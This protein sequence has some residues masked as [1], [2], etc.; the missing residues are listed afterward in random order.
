MLLA[1]GRLSMMSVWLKSLPTSVITMR[2]MT[3]VM[4]PGV[5]GTTTRMG[6]DGYFVCAQTSAVATAINAPATD[7]ANSARKLIDSPPAY[8]ELL[9]E[10]PRVARS[11]V[12]YSI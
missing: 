6:R 8:R 10:R 3:S 4:P 9:N 12:S 1:P 2:V 7:H 5:Y 11:D